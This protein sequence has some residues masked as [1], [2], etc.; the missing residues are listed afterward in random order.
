MI[1]ANDKTQDGEGG[2]PP[3]QSQDRGNGK[4]LMGWGNGTSTAGGQ[5]WESLTA[6]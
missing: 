2:A 3:P 6:E 4:Q 5:V 1:N